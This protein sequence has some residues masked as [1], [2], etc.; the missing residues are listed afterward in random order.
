MAGLFAFLAL[1]CASAAA[2]TLLGDGPTSPSFVPAVIATAAI[3]AA[4]SVWMF[5]DLEN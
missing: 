5:F 1:A 3:F 4:F 2:T